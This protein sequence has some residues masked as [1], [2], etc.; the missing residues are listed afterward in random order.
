MVDREGRSEGL[1]VFFWKDSIY[2]SIISFSKHQIDLEI[3]D[4]MKGVWCLT[5][6]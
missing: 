2:C 6:F 4:T 3:R 1:G 5:G